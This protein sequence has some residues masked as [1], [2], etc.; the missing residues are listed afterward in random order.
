MQTSDEQA[1][2][3]SSLH[4]PYA[5]PDWDEYF[6]DG[7]QWVSDRADCRRRKVGAVI[8][9]ENRIVATGYNGAE[10]G[11]PSCLRGECPRGLASASQVAPGSSYDTG[12]GVCVAIHAEQNAI[13]YCSRE[14]RLGATIYINQEPCGGCMRMLRG[15]GLARAVWPEGEVDL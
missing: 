12:A 14:D 9:K 10:P 3:L 8:V 7:A 1:M 5:R 11:G 4:D 6:L 2:A 13:M 15:S